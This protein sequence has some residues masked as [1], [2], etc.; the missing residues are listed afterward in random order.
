MKRE[1]HDRRAAPP[2]TVT[3]KPCGPRCDRSRAAS[4][5]EGMRRPAR[6]G[7]WKAHTSDRLPTE[8]LARRGPGADRR[9]LHEREQRLSRPPF[10]SLQPMGQAATVQPTTDFPF[11]EELVLVGCRVGITTGHDPSE[12]PSIRQPASTECKA[13]AH[14]ARAAPRDNA[15]PPYPLSS[16]AYPSGHSRPSAPPKEASPPTRATCRASTG[17]CA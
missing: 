15:L 17:S 5:P 2:P 4:S 16:G 12:F 11:S 9:I 10:V 6:A 7:R 1:Y 3:H 14:A 8:V 13:L